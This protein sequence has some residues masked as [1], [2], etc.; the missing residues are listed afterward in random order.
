VLPAAND[1]T[2][3][4]QDATTIEHAIKQFYYLVNW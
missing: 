1:Y 2:S 3:Y 4:L